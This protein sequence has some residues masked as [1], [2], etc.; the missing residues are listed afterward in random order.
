MESLTELYYYAR[1]YS[2]AIPAYLHR[3]LEVGKS[4]AN[5]LL[6]LNGFLPITTD[7]RQVIDLTVWR[8][9]FSTVGG[10]FVGME[11]IQ[12]HAELQKIYYTQTILFKKAIN[13]CV[14]QFKAGDT[15]ALRAYLEEPWVRLC[16]IKGHLTRKMRQD[17]VGFLG[18]STR[19]Q[20]HDQM[21][22]L[23]NILEEAYRYLNYFSSDGKIQRLY[24]ILSEISEIEMDGKRLI[25]LP[26]VQKILDA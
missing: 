5:E 10:R 12:T 9:L 3:R 1:I 14:L 7:D 24:S 11:N 23:A 8:M 13:Y 17:I 4:L 26:T 15:T 18:G 25:H 22:S 2:E 21:V 6:D 16:L 20:I 19:F